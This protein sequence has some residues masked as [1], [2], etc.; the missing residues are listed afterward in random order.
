M[1]DLRAVLP[2]IL[3]VLFGVLIVA[4][5]TTLNRRSAAIREMLRGIVEPAGWTTLTNVSFIGSGLK[6]EWRQFPAEFVFRQRQKGAP[7]RFI[8]RI[9]ARS[10]TYLN[11]KRRF[12]GFFSNKPLTWFGAPLIDVHQPAA[13][14]FWVRGDPSLAERIFSDPK[15]A[16]LIAANLVARF[17]EL[18]VDGSGLRITRA[19]DDRNVR[20]KYN[21]PSFT[22]AFNARQF[23]PIAH[24]QI[25]LAEAMV[26][27]LG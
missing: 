8:L 9:S 6:G 7:Q 4:L 25:V 13:S 15:V 11:V 18:Q 1:Q 5:I 17:D 26:A 23:E 14:Q 2:I 3:F 24:E 12:E 22:M 21:M 19:L 27:K 16:S 10:D 20:M